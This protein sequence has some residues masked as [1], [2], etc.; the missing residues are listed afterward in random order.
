LK[1]L[2]R[3]TVILVLTLLFV[4]AVR[5]QGQAIVG[6][7]NETSQ[8][9]SFPDAVGENVAPRPAAS[10]QL[11]DSSSNDNLLDDRDQQ[12]THDQRTSDSQ[13]PAGTLEKPIQQNPVPTRDPQT[14]RIAGVL[15][16][17]HAVSTDEVLPPMTV[18]QKFLTAF[19]DSFDYSSVFIPAVVAGASM[20]R[21]ATP[22]FGQGAVRYGCYFWHA[23]VDQT[24]ANFLVEFIVPSLTHE[25][26][27]YYTLGRGG[28]FKRTAYALSRAVVTRTDSG[29][30]TFNFSEVVGSGAASGISSLYYPS[31][32]RSFRNVGI[33][34]GTDIGIDAV[35]RILKEFWPDINRKFVHQ[36][37]SAEGA[38]H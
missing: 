31:R 15:P 28:M 38:K 17:F 23:A 2:S 22:E 36:S 14:K 29:R 30:N 37:D 35:S 27:R 25:D 7:R 12:P 26:N 13:K 20:A 24:S 9:A 19:D 21:K 6:S 4:A 34:W 11:P 33:E 32:E 18:K 8:R 1:H 16:N 10:G 3:I 5:V